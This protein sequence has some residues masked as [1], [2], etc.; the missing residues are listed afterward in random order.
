[1]VPLPGHIPTPARHRDNYSRD[2]LRPFSASSRV[3]SHVFM[4][5][6][7]LVSFPTLEICREV[8]GVWETQLTLENQALKFCA[9]RVRFDIAANQGLGQ[10]RAVWEQK[11]WIHRGR[12]PTKRRENEADTEKGEKENGIPPNYSF[13]EHW[14]LVF[15]KIFPYS[16]NFLFTWTSLS[17]FQS[18]VNHESLIFCFLI[19][20]LQIE[21]PSKN[22]LV[23]AGVCLK[24]EPGTRSRRRR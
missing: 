16:I 23:L 7:K 8:R 1:M 22:P 14:W 5:K 18:L 10:A 6:F 12:E 20:Y 13:K 21:P 9:F 15:E 19:F 3:S 17:T 24:T 4:P 2:V 11:S